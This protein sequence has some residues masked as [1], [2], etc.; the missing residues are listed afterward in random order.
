VKEGGGAE[1]ECEGERVHWGCYYATALDI[2]GDPQRCSFG[3]RK[4]DFARGDHQDLA[5]F[6]NLVSVNS[7]LVQ[8]KQ[9]LG[10]RAEPLTE[11]LQ[12]APKGR[13]TRTPPR[14]PVSPSVLSV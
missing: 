14:S 5:S 8:Y 10:H 12:R 3:S 13:P 11:L 9:A 1:G 6:N 2:E 4:S 7:M